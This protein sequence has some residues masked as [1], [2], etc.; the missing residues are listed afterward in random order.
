MEVY[1]MTEKWHKLE[2]S[3]GLKFGETKQGEGQKKRFTHQ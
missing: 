1:K 3:K 2:G